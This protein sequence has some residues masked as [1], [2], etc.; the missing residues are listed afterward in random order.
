MDTLDRVLLQQNGENNVSLLFNTHRC[1]CRQDANEFTNTNKSH[2]LLVL[3]LNRE[4]TDSEL[5]L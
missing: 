2:F 4:P 3:F 1:D 5:L